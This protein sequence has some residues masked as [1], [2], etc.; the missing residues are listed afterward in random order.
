MSA[1]AT[2]VITT[3]NRKDELRP[4][5]QSALDQTAKPQVIVID[6]GS[7]DGTSE[8]VRAEFPTVTLHRS[9][10]SLGLIAQRNRGA[11]LAAGEIVLSIDDDAIFSTRHVVEQTLAEF[12]QRRIGA[13][14]IPFTNVKK[15][16]VVRQK[17][18]AGEGIF[19]T[20]AYIGTAHALRRDI[21]LKLG[22]YR[23]HLIHQGEEG[24]LCIRL[25][26]AGYVV[27]L[28]RADP[29]HHFESPKRSSRRM[30]LFGRRNDIL[31]GWHNVPLIDLPARWIRANA[32]GLRHGVRRRQIWW[33]IEGFACGY[34]G[35]LKF[36]GKRAPVSRSI[37]RLYRELS[38][39]AVPLERIESQLPPLR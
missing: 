27:A 20:G 13:V 2:V 30:T 28:G 35:V 38:G 33:T 15:D 21:F 31:F 18:P 37:Y 19:V 11:E 17:A 32:G 9:E 26:N 25:L 39:A 22:G 7:N 36:A 3:K 12:S 23:P 24:D 4:A 1:P 10:T 34:G 6:D 14:A 16:D 29:I 5:I 8:M